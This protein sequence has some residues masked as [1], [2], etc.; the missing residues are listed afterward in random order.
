MKPKIYS[1]DEHKIPHHKIDNHAYYVIQKLRT[2]GFSAY[3]VGGGV[4]DLLL[5]IRPKDFDISTSA[6]PEEIRKVFKNCFL[7]G[8]RF[9]LAHVRFGKNIIEVSTFRSGETEA[10][11][12][13]VRDNVWGSEVEDVLRRDFTINGLFYDPEHQTVIDYVGGM[14]D[15]EKKTLRT[16]GKASSRFIQDPVRMIRLLKFKARFGFSIDNDALEALE[17]CKNHITNSSPARI[18]EELLRML[19]SGSSKQFFQILNEYGLVKLL[20]P[21]LEKHLNEPFVSSYLSQVDIYTQKNRLL[22]TDRSLLVSCLLFPILDKKLQKMSPHPHLGQ[23]VET[24][25][26]LINEIFHPF[27]HVPKKLQAMVISILSNQYRLV[28]FINK[29]RHRIPYD[30]FFPLSMKFLQIRCQIDPELHKTY[31]SWSETLFN[32]HKRRKKTSSSSS[33]SVT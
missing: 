3:L 28:P 8:R 18:F 32:S 23:V 21:K 30:P 10:T 11:E 24:C 22:P 12:L 6:K 25:K 15:L 4:R 14:E 5:N 19:E 31:T 13:I 2:A 20:M 26:D 16:I 7:V 33:S 1:L 9:R 27:F 29:K 17:L